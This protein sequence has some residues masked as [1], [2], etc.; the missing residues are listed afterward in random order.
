M[1]TSG[2][3]FQSSRFTLAA[4]LFIAHMC[5]LSNTVPKLDEKVLVIGYPMGG[6]T[7]SVT[8]GV[9][10]RVT[11]LNYGTLMKPIVVP[12]ILAVQVSPPVSFLVLC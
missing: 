10:S 5:Q 7:I 4:L 1:R 9:V 6:D 12:N 2:R 11:T 8:R 3:I